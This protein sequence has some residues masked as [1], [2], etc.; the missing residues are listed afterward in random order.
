LSSINPLCPLGAV[1]VNI[2]K[3]RRKLE[4]HY[5]L[6]D[7]LGEGQYGTVRAAVATVDQATVA[8]K[9]TSK[10]TFCMEV[11]RGFSSECD[12]EVQ[13][14]F[15]VAWQNRRQVTKWEGL[16][17][18]AEAGPWLLRKDSVVKVGD[19]GAA[20]ML[21]NN[22]VDAN[23]TTWIATPEFCAPEL[24]EAR[25]NNS[26]IYGPEV[27]D[28]ALKDSGYFPFN[29]SDEELAREVRAGINSV[30]MP[31]DLSGQAIDFIKCLLQKEPSERLCGVDSVKR[32]SF[33]RGFAWGDEAVDSLPGMQS[34]D[35][36]PPPAANVEVS[37]PWSGGSSEL[38]QPKEIG[39][40]VFEHIML[41]SQSPAT[42]AV[43]RLRSDRCTAVNLTGPNAPEKNLKENE[44]RGFFTLC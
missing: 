11:V 14:L 22:K 39:F 31:L 42:E 25:S 26:A 43:G 33:L 10:C 1:V 41:Q 28:P 17:C 27:A 2:V 4:D 19:L 32:H 38:V 18:I 44:A 29:G 6:G 8:V 5:I 12:A 21:V 3:K 9:T 36:G 30:A 24:L 23:F 40:R 20:T 16:H 34:L 37:M 15:I 7:S 35:Q 13:A